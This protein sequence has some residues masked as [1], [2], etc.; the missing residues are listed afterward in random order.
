MK[1]ALLVIDV[2]NGWLAQSEGLKVST[3]L[4][5]GKMLAA[6]SIFHKANAPVIFTFHSYAEAGVVPGATDFE[7]V[8][9]IDVAT[10]DGRVVKTHLNA[11][12]K[13]E[14]A[15]LVRARGCDTVVLVGLSA[16]HCVLS[17]YLGAYDYDF[18][19]YLVRGAVAAPDEGSVV[20]AERLCDTLSLRAIAQILGQ[21]SSGMLVALKR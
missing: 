9:G 18:A 3:D 5:L 15:N 2:Q 13:T 4:R 21:P 6:I 8:P 1:P 14:L 19:P 7:V 10:A 17:T 12:S 16:L 11:F 20:T